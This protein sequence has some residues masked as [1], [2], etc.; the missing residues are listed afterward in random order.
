MIAALIAAACTCT[1][2]ATATGL[3]K[4]APVEFFFA[5]QDSDNAYETMFLVDD[6]IDDFC[7]KIEAAGIFAKAPVAAKA[8]PNCNICFVTGEQMKTEL[9]AFLQIMFEAAPQSIGGALPADDFYCI[10]K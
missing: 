7:R 10:L 5:A 6:S 3:E 8:I 1:F 9:S 4:G 2:S